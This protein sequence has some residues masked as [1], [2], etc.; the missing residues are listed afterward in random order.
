MCLHFTTL[1]LWFSSEG[2]SNYLQE[3][4]CTVRDYLWSSNTQDFP[5]YTC[6]TSV[7]IWVSS[8]ENRHIRFFI[9]VLPFPFF[10]VELLSSHSSNLS[11]HNDCKQNICIQEIALSQ[12]AF[13]QR[14]A[15]SPQMEDTEKKW[16]LP[17]SILTHTYVQARHTG[18]HIH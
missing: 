18:A 7:F 3:C 14:M 9:E 4:V 16:P 1:G 11:S 10:I 2:C 15:T 13:L 5:L 6:F 12:C 8:S 17:R